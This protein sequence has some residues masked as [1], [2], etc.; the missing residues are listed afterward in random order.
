MAA[1]LY[2]R[3][4]RI[5]DYEND[6]GPVLP[7]ELR[8]HLNL[9]EAGL[10]TAANIKTAFSCTTAQSSDMDA[11]LGTMPTTLLTF[12]NAVQ[13]AR[14]VDRIY[15]VFVAGIA[16]WPAFDSVAE[17]KTALGIS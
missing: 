5:G 2:E 4:L 6:G 7:D 12:L 10:T 15:S 17:C 9:Y 11:L 3:I 14:W 1:N 16:G 8:I 13:R